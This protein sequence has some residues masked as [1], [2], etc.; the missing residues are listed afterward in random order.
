VHNWFIDELDMAN[1]VKKIDNGDKMKFIHLKAPNPVKNQNI[2]GFSRYMPKQFKLEKYVDKNLMFQKT[3]VDAI[4]HILDAIGW[5]V[6]K[7][8]SLN[9]FFG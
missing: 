4:K 9:S 5:D 8:A 6:E 1:E 2:I 7:K 3:F